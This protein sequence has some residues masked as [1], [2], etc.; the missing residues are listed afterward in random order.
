[1]V[2]WGQLFLVETV[3]IKLVWVISSFETITIL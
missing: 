3:K 2:V 1:L